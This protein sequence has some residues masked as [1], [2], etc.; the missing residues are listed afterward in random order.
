M[1]KTLSILS[2]A[3]F[4]ICSAFIISK[5]NG[6]VEALILTVLPGMA[7]QLLYYFKPKLAVIF[8][9]AVS[10]SLG[11]LNPFIG[12]LSAGICFSVLT[13][14]FVFNLIGRV[15]SIKPTRKINRPE[16]AVYGD[17]EFS[18]LTKAKELDFDP[19]FSL[20]DSNVHH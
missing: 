19:K 6:G 16:N 20:F 18:S 15:L 14:N 1:K 12:L 8:A 17:P 2:A 13:I 7:Y 9:I 4:V 5:T 10:V 11:V 3:V